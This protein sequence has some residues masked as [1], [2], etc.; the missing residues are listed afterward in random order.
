MVS[1][2]TYYAHAC[3]TAPC[4]AK[5]DPGSRRKN[6]RRCASEGFS[7]YRG[8]CAK[9]NALPSGRHHVCMFKRQHGPNRGKF[10]TRP[11]TRDHT[12]LCAMHKC[13]LN[14][15]LVMRSAFSYT[16]AVFA[17]FARNV[18]LP[19]DLLEVIRGHLL[20]SPTR[21]PARCG[22]C[23]RPLTTTAAPRRS[24]STTPPR[25]R[26]RKKSN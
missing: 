25:R 22:A 15:Q 3:A 8:C 13:R 14:E 17:Q 5:V 10:C 16:E 4:G 11:L 26:C 7:K 9:H 6:A 1:N 12:F 21:S 18:P 24:W 2:P 19:P 23:R 20:E